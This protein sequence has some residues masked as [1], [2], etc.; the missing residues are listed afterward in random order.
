MLMSLLS[1]IL[2]GRFSYNW[3]YQ[4]W[5][6]RNSV[7]SLCLCLH[8]LS[9]C[10]HVLSLCL[11]LACFC[12][13]FWSSLPHHMQNCCQYGSVLHQFF[14]LYTADEGISS[15]SFRIIHV[16]PT[17]D[18]PHG[19]LPFWSIP[20]SIWFYLWLLFLL[21][22]SPPSYLLVWHTAILVH[23]HSVGHVV[24]WSCWAGSSSVLLRHRKETGLGDHV[25]IHPVHLI[26]SVN[27]C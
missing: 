18:V 1:V 24:L 7:Q 26:N 27:S 9:L 3:F 13:Q 16:Y 4:D 22:T 21:A 8:V 11:L 5:I 23:Y 17:F 15:R 19:I 2:L 12:S 6:H 10:L 14:P 20:Y 25:D